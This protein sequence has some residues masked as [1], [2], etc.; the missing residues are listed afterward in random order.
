MEQY[1]QLTQ[2]AACDL[3]LVCRLFPWLRMLVWL[4]NCGYDD[5]TPPVICWIFWKN[6]LEFLICVLHVLW[7]LFDERLSRKK[8]WFILFVQEMYMGN[9]RSVLAARWQDSVRWAIF[10]WLSWT[11]DKTCLPMASCHWPGIHTLTVLRRF[12]ITSLSSVTHRGVAAFFAVL[13]EELLNW[14]RKES[15]SNFFLLREAEKNESTPRPVL[16]L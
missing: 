14:L 13:F 9:G 15:R 4:N 1:A 2:L 8:L 6:I 11:S 5:C 16:H 7:Q 12:Q 3:I 10:G